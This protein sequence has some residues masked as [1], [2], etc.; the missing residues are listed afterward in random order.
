MHDA[1][2]D[3]DAAY[4]LGGTRVLGPSMT[5]AA[6]SSAAARLLAS[7]AG[8]SSISPTRR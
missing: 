3:G 6:S 2:I 5:G 8:M 4:D 7:G 1:W